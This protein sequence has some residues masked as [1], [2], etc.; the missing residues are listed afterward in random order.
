MYPSRTRVHDVLVID[1]I[2]WLIMLSSVPSINISAHLPSRVNYLHSLSFMG[3]HSDWKL[4]I[5]L[6]VSDILLL[7]YCHVSNANVMHTLQFAHATYRN[8]LVFLVYS[9][10]IDPHLPIIFITLSNFITQSLSSSHLRG[11]QQKRPLTR[12]PIFSAPKRNF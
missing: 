1:C 2:I 11:Q 9:A 4:L 6:L 7:Y 5:L 3:R 10:M 8:S 12:F